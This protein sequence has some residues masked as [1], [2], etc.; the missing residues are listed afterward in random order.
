MITIHQLTSNAKPRLRMPRRRGQR[1]TSAKATNAERQPPAAMI[2]NTAIGHGSNTTT[3][4]NSSIT[5]T[6]LA[7]IVHGTS[8]TFSGG[9]LA[10]AIV[11]PDPNAGAVYTASQVLGTFF[12]PMAGTVPAGGAGTYNAVAATSVCNLGTAATASTTFTFADNGSELR[13]GSFRGLWHNRHVHNFE[14]EVCIF[15]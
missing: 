8:F 12:S 4:G 1:Q 11:F 2:G 15:R 13:H 7:G 10:H 14:R 6:Y 3:L 5:D 9:G